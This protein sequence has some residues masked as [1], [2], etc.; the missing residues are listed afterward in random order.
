MIENKTA[1]KEHIIAPTT[2]HDTNA[3]VEQLVQKQCMVDFSQ[4]SKDITG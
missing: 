3:V 2:I 4:S 1:A